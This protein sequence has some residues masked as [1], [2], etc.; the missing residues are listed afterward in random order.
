M[1]DHRVWTYHCAHCGALTTGDFPDEV[2][3]PVQY[4]PRLQRLVGYLGVEQLL[5]LRRIGQVVYTLTDA[6]LSDETIYRMIQSSAQHF[7]PVHSH[8]GELVKHAP[9]THVD[10]TG[11]RVKGSLKW[12]HVG[13]TAANCSFWL[14]TSRG[15]VMTEATGI[16]VHDHW[17]SY[18]SNISQAQHELFGSSGA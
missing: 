13:T 12:F 9:V 15:D 16:A 5:P 7:Q 4:G 14:G 6:R 11:M 2:K 3:A 1:T 8:W 10:E 17:P 18:Q